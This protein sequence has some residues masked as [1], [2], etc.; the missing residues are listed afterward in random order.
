MNKI[1]EL[2]VGQKIELNASEYELANDDKKERHPIYEVVE[3]L[4]VNPITETAKVEFPDGQW[5]MIDCDSEFNTLPSSRKL[6]P[7][8]VKHSAVKKPL[9]YIFENGMEA[10]III[11][12][13]SNRYKIGSVA[14]HVGNCTK[15]IIRAPFKSGLE[16]LEKAKESLDMAID[17]WKEHTK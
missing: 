9:H 5:S 12:M 2:E 15:Y 1:A 10:K 3:V 7:K 8:K 13:I 11:N 4:E 6:E 14:Y 16:D 17:C